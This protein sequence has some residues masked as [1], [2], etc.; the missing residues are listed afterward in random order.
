M[1]LTG[2][3]DSVDACAL[4]P[5]G[6]FAL[7][8][9]FDRTLKLWDPWSGRCL[10]TLL[11]RWQF[12]HGFRGRGAHLRGRHAGNVWVLESGAPKKKES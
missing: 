7:S 3:N 6:R 10:Q 11:W 4:T 9:S 5:D 1:T 8:A 2:H 12:H